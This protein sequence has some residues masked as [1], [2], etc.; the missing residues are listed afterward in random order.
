MTISRW[1]LSRGWRR[2]WRCKF[3]RE[4]EKIPCA[5]KCAGYLF[6]CFR[7][8]TKSFLMQRARYYLQYFLHWRRTKANPF[9]KIPHGVFVNDLKRA[10]KEGTIRKVWQCSERYKVK[11][12]IGCDNRHVDEETLIKAYIMAWNAIVKNRDDF[13]EQWKEQMKSD[14]LLEGY[15][16]EKFI[17]YTEDAHPITEMDTDFMLKTLDHIKVSFDGTLTVVFLDGTEIECKK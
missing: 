2:K 12:V 4:I 16:A 17:E 1:N 11:G 8:S 7:F 6:C 14:N 5:R 9:R 13:M 3:K 10:S 15:R